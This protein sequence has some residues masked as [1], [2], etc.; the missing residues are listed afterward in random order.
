MLEG[1]T[2]QMEGKGQELEQGQNMGRVECWVA[3]NARRNQGFCIR[4]G[5]VDQNVG[6]D[7][8]REVGNRVG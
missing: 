4:G 7:R 6:Q 1:R 8:H 3:Q 2:G 5:R